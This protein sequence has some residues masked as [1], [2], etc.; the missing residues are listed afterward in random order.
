[1]WDEIAKGASLSRCY[2]WRG[3]WNGKPHMVRMKMELMS[4]RR[5]PKLKCELQ[6]GTVR[7]RVREMRDYKHRRDL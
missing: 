7:S 3:W 5:R 1:M 6:G 4:G 2:E